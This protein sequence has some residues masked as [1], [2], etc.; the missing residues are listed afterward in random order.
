MARRPTIGE[1]LR[2][3]AF[4]AVFYGATVFI[5]L[6][7]VA[8]LFL[9]SEERFR[10]V[11]HWWGRFHRWCV[12]RILAIPVIIE[13]TPPPP[14]TLVALKHEAFMEAIELPQ[15][16]PLPVVFAKAELMRIPL[17][18]LAGNRYG[19]VSVEREEGAAALRRMLS[20]AKRLGQGG[21]RLAIFPEGTRVRHGTRPPLQS[22][23]AA[24]YKLL[25]RPVIPVAV[26]SG[27]AY[28]HWIK[29]R[30]PI[31]VRYMDAIPAGLP[32]DEVEARVHA[33]IN[34]LNS[35]QPG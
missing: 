11:I 7:S 1:V 14:G 3:I 2:S 5:V 26:R 34:A 17:W 19:L 28:H 13:G 21:R 9:A 31:V 27:P 10:T 20:A 22:G 18:G 12:T 23:F 8:T 15:L 30:V 32:R 35:D 29:R 33:A 4:Y 24:L 25:G 6:M 16:M